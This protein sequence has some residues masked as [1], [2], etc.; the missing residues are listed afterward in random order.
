ML[1]AFWKY[2]KYHFTIVIWFLLTRCANRFPC[3]CEV[4]RCKS[5]YTC[6]CTHTC[7]SLYVCVYIHINVYTYVVFY[8]R[9]AGKGCQVLLLMKV[10]TIVVSV[11]LHQYSLENN[12]ALYLFY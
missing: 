9:M 6:A 5:F 10:V 11:S 12:L 2:Q 8:I 4:L 1:F 3:Y 7:I